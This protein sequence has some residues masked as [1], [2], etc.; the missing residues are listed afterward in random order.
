MPLKMIVVIAFDVGWLVGGVLQYAASLL[1]SPVPLWMIAVLGSGL[2]CSILWSINDAP[3][4][5]WWSE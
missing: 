3:W 4:R 2:T 1:C 5:R